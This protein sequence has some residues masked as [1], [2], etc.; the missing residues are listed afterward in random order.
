MRINMPFRCLVGGSTLFLALV[1]LGCDREPPPFVCGDSIGCVDVGPDE[2]LKFGVLQALSGKVAPLGQEQ[3][4]GIELA[5]VKCQ[6]MLLGHPVVLQIEDDGCTAEGGANAALKV[7]A[8][9]QTVA[10]L[11]STCSGAAVTASAAMSKAGLTMISGNNSAPFLTA[12]AGKAAPHRQPGYFRTA[13]NEEVSGKAAAHYAYEKLG[14]RRAATIN[15]GDIYTRGLT[16]GFEDA[17]RQ[18]GGEIV[19]STAVDKGDEQMQPFLTAVLNAEAQ[20]LF[21]PLFQPEGN[22]IL[23]QGREMAGFEQVAL[24]SDGALIEKSFLEAVGDKGKGLYFVGP[25][26]PSGPAV[27]ALEQQYRLTFQSS[28][29]AIYYQNAYDSVNLLFAAIER[30]AVKEA[31]GTLH[32]GRQALRESMA[33]IR[34]DDGVSGQLFCD[35]FGDCARP[36]FNVL[37]LD[38]PATGIEGLLANVLFTYGPQP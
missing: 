22:R 19:L 5:L 11:G 17:F 12:I 2:P 30:V 35:E 9:P 14:I 20:L 13:S 38:D 37:R 8:D 32:I 16:E 10:I 3:M 29:S 21:F 1:G 7:I 33:A 15:D 34:M 31:D 28:P 24:M 27:D 4:R 26:K 25:A 6:K 36:I 18:L 23:I